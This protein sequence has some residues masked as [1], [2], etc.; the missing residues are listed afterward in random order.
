MLDQGF[1]RGT[2]AFASHD[3]IIQCAFQR[4]HQLVAD[5]VQIL[6]LSGHHARPAQDVD[7]IDFPFVALHFDPVGGFNQLLGQ[8]FVQD[9]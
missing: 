1:Q 7:W 8:F 9:H 5:E 3:E 6:F 2:F 4:L